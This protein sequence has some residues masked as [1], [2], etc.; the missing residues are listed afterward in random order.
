MGDLIVSSSSRASEVKPLV[1]LHMQSLAPTPFRR[2]VDVRQ[3]GSRKK[4]NFRI[5]ITTEIHV[6]PIPLT[7]SGIRFGNEITVK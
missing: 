6:V 7:L 1:R 4:N 3:A 2:R 5:F